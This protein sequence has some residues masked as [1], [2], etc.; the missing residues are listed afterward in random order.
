MKIYR[1]GKVTRE[2]VKANKHILFVFGDN[3]L[4]IGL[5]GM[6][7]EC[8]GEFNTLGIRTKKKPATTIDSYY[9]DDEFV[10][11]CKKI[12]EDITSI[13]SYLIACKDKGLSRSIYIPHGIGCGLAK[14]HLYAPRTNEYLCNQIR[15]LIL[16]LKDNC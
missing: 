10:E 7:K 14:L 1:T 13:L 4:R 2:Y 11:N 5:G 16:H 9:T 8:R 6:A 3:D 12:D 15:W